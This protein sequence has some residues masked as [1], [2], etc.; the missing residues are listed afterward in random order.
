VDGRRSNATWRSYGN[1][2]VVTPEI[3]GLEPK[4]A[5]TG[6]EPVEH[7]GRLRQDESAAFAGEKAWEWMI[8]LDDKEAA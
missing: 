2:P 4:E 3:Q 7:S 5:T 8:W 6:I 1:V